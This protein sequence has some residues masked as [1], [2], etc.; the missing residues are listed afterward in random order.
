M[1]VLM[2]YWTKLCHNA[3]EARKRMLKIADIDVD[4]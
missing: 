3:I 1:Q 4:H 2:T